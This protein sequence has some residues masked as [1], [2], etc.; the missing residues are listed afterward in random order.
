MKIKK[1]L[2]TALTAALVVSPTAEASDAK[3][4]AGFYVAIKAIQVT[5]LS[6][7]ADMWKALGH[8]QKAQETLGIAK[9]LE[10]GD[11]GPEVAQ[12]A[13][14]V[15]SAEVQA[16][17]EQLEAVGAPLTKEQRAAATSAYLKIAG[18]TVLWVGALAA[19][20]KSLESDE[21]DGMTKLT[22][23]LAMAGEVAEAGGATNQLLQA[24]RA[25]SQFNSGLRGLKA[26]SKEL[27]K[28]APLL[29]SL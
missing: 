12:N 2:L 23:G 15:A 10:K 18:T 29:A 6:G 28:E 20:K 8:A 25:Y 1:I 27:M 3:Y 5:A 13:M 4:M 24:W 17:I 21:I 22:V 7:T 14:K 9:D 16:Q 19:A 26:P 11:L